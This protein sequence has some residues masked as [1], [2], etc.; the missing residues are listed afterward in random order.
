MIFFSPMGPG[1][2]LFLGTSNN[3]LCIP[4]VILYIPAMISQPAVESWM[5]DL[6]QDAD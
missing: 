2:F 1:S 5:F 6:F 4:G 3:I